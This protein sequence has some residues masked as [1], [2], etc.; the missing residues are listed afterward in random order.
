M[1]YLIVLFN[2]RE[3]ISEAEYE[4]WAKST[5]LPTVRG[6][7]SVDGFDVYKSL[8]IMGSEAA[9]PFRYVEI[10]KINDMELMGQEAGSATMQKVA[11]EFQGR[12][13]DNPIFMICDNLEG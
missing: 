11:S 3:G 13:A 10:I 8:A 12:L 1:K 4:A 9:P 7:N 6:L 2:L 5:D